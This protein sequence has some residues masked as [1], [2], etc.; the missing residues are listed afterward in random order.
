MGTVEE[1]QW[2]FLRESDGRAANVV[3]LRGEHWVWL[4]EMFGLEWQ[5]P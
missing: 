1:C 3:K 5:N 4:I 2:Y